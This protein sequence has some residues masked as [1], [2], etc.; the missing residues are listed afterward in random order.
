MSVG[1]IR[2][3]VGLVY[4]PTD[5]GYKPFLIA[6]KVVAKKTYCFSDK[7]TILVRHALNQVEG[8]NC[9]SKFQITVRLK[10]LPPFFA[11]AS[12]TKIQNFT[13]IV[14]RRPRRASF[15]TTRNRRKLSTDTS[16]VSRP[17]SA[18]SATARLSSPTKTG[19]SFT[20]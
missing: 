20:A 15:S 12:A 10:T 6:I 16:S 18:P 4:T 14:C 2:M 9:I 3:L 17:T 7:L 1:K 5:K 11:D 19:F 8:H 13:N